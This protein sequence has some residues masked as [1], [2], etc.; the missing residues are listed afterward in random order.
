MALLAGMHAVLLR[1]LFVCMCAELP[2]FPRPCPLLA[3]FL[4][5]LLLAPPHMQIVTHGLRAHIQVGGFGPMLGQL[6]HFYRYA[7]EDVPY[8]KVCV[9]S[10]L[11]L[12]GY[13]RRGNAH[14]QSASAERARVGAPL[15]T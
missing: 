14:K 15:G 3:P 8:A 7:P 6:G 1:A 10:C 4:V 12:R 11:C 13:F 2:G 5:S 9:L